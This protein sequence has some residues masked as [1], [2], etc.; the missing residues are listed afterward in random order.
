MWL[1]VLG[2]CHVERAIRRC[3]RRAVRRCRR[4][5]PF[6]ADGAA[7]PETP[8][9]AALLSSGAVERL[10]ATRWGSR[11]AAG[12]TAPSFVVDA[13]WPKPLPNE[14][15]IGQVGGIAVDSHDHIWI[16]HRPRTLDASSAGALPR[17][18]TNAQGVPIDALGQSR[19]LAEQNTGCCVPAPSVLEVDRDGNL[20]AAWG[21]PSDPGFLDNNCREADGCFWPAREHGIYVDQDDFVYLSG[22]GED[23]GARQQ[24]GIATYPWAPSFGDDS[25]VLKFTAAG[26]FVYQIGVAGKDAP[27]SEKIDGGPNGTPQPYLAAD[28]SV[29]SKTKRLYIA[30]GYGNRR[31]LIVDAATGK[32]IGHFGAYGQN[33]VVDDPRSGVADTEVGPWI[34][35]FQA[36]RLKPPFFRSPVHCATVSRDGFLYVCDRGNNRVQIFK[37]DAPEL[38]RPCANPDG[39][40]GK[41]GFVAE[42]RVAPQTASG[43]SGTAA[44]ST[45][46]GQTCLYVGDLANGT[47]YVID[48]ENRT[49]L[50]RIGRAG[51]QAGEFHWLHAL[52]VDSHGDIYTGEV[53][54][55][56]RVQRFMRYGSESCAGTGS[57]EV[58]LYGAN[59]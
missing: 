53:D 36:G 52:A 33:P 48:R 20:L 22:N 51:R 37:L 32:Y 57:A 2:G 46:A 27:D 8:A 55:G 40:A 47:L 30:D 17:V 23:G 28:M 19:A 24:Q 13:S 5:R 54:T 15:R 7:G 29:D 38:G 35:D 4:L 1:K 6:G 39:E 42:I 10:G 44:L 21:G 11:P 14:W 16:Y 18:A 9:A 50:D 41:C 45:D 59:R 34:A 3:R 56:Q 12:V 25:H 31:I 43:T 26:K 58:G 49:E